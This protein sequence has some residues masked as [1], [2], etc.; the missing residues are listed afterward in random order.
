MKCKLAVLCLIGFDSM[1]TPDMNRRLVLLIFLSTAL[2]SINA[3]SEV[4]VSIIPKPLRLQVMDGTFELKPDTVIRYGAG[5]KETA[6][7][8]ASVLEPATGFEFSVRRGKSK[9]G[10]ISLTLDTELLPELGGEG[11]RLNVGDEGVQIRAAEDAGLF[12]AVQSLRQLL[13]AEIFSS[14]KR[15]T[16]WTLPYVHIEDKPRFTWRGMHLDVARHFMPKDFILKFIDLLAMHKLNTFHWHLTEDQGWRIEIKKYPRLTDVGAW[17]DETVVGHAGYYIWN[18]LPLVYDGIPHGGFYTQEEVK[19]VVAFAAERHIR[20]VPEI[21]LPG[22]AQAAIAAYPEFASSDEQLTVK[23]EWGVSH[24]IYSP[25]EKTIEF[26]KAIFDE[27]LPLFPSEFIHIGG[28]EAKKTLWEKSSRIQALREERGL[29]DMDEMQS[30]FIRQFDDYLTERGRRLIGWDEIL[31][32]GL[33]PGAT[34]MS[35]R[36][37]EGGIA[38]AKKGQDV[39]MANH[40]ALYFNHYQGNPDHEPLAQGGHT[41]LEQ[42]YNYNPV[43]K[44]LNEKQAKHVLGAQGQLWTEYIPHEK[45]AEYMA[46]PSTTA[47]SEVVWLPE[48]EKDYGRFYDSLQI[49]LKR[50]GLLNVN[51]R[52]LH[53]DAGVPPRHDTPPPKST[54]G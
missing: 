23:K 52:P 7:Y 25:E 19:E 40:E 45:H 14:S 35:W 30:W 9:K 8:L 27:I 10:D 21:E 11:Y 22:H 50:L 32:G 13:P 42:V 6:Q 4:M 15:L 39:V 28:D 37:D 41:P 36:G 2:L 3:A 48:S 51:F 29:K 17:R 20:V 43:P 53:L 46:F 33:A 18:D 34:V 44:A 26:L 16:G 12:Y 38:A 1:S 24:H 5:A 49:H 54:E 31:E 47:L